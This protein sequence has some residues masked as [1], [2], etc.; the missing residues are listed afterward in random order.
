MITQIR[1]RSFE[2]GSEN[3]SVD[4]SAAVMSVAREK[5][6]FNVSNDLPGMMLGDETA[7]GGGHGVGV[8]QALQEERERLR[9]LLV[10][11]DYEAEFLKQRVPDSDPLSEGFGTAV[12]SAL[13]VAGMR[14]SEGSNMR[15]QNWVSFFSSGSLVEPFMEAL[16]VFVRDRIQMPSMDPGHA[17]VENMNLVMRVTEVAKT[18]LSSLSQIRDSIARHIHVTDHQ[19]KTR[20]RE[21]LP[22]PGRLLPTAPPLPSY[23]HSRW[24]LSSSLITAFEQIEALNKMVAQRLTALQS[25][26]ETIIRW[27][28]SFSDF[29]SYQ[30][31]FVLGSSMRAAQPPPEWPN[32]PPPSTKGTKLGRF[33]PLREGPP[34]SPNKSSNIVAPSFTQLT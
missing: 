31:L 11:L 18:L 19:L 17:L 34:P 23:E 26:E 22:H 27:F 21:G 6:R 15:V 29:C 4:F 25:P 8:G 10:L 28:T 24:A 7:E 33:I 14:L 30:G 16:A 1:N 12:V 13:N 9:C 2:V 3:T 5:S 32:G 20:E